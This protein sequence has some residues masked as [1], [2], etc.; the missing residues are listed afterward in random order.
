MLKQ[1]EKQPA[2]LKSKS[3][4]L[5]IDSTGADEFCSS[6][7]YEPTNIEESVLGN[8]Y[9][10]GEV[11]TF[12]KKCAYLVN[13]LASVIKKE[14]YRNHKRSPLESFEAGLSKANAY[15]ANI[16][17]QENID[18]I[19][20]IDIVCALLGKNQI[21]IS[22]VGDAR[23]LLSRDNYISPITEDSPQ[24]EPP[25][26]SKT[27]SNITSGP[28]IP[29]DKIVLST[30]GLFNML[31]LEEI[32]HSI[33]GISCKQAIQNIGELSEMDEDAETSSIILLDIDDPTASPQ[34]S[35]IQAGQLNKNQSIESLITSPK[36]SLKE[37][38]GDNSNYEQ[39]KISENELTNVSENDYKN[40]LGLKEKLQ[41]QIQ[42][43]FKK[44]LPL[45]NKTLLLLFKFSQ[46]FINLSLNVIKTIFSQRKK[47][48]N[49]FSK[50][51]VENSENNKKSVIIKIKKNIPLSNK[52]I[53]A[54]KS[55]FIFFTSKLAIKLTAVALIITFGTIGAFLLRNK[56][57]GNMEEISASLNIEKY[58]KL[59][60][61][62]Q[63]KKQD[64][65]TA[66]IYKDE[67][68]AKTLLAE[69]SEIIEESIQLGINPKE[70]TSLKNDIQIQLD[71]I[72]KI[73]NLQSPFSISDLKEISQD[74][75][76]KAH[77]IFGS[78]K[79]LMLLDY[80]N[81]QVAT[82]NLAKYNLTNQRSI[83]LLPNENIINSAI[84]KNGLICAI[85]NFSTIL[86]IPLEDIGV[87]HQNIVSS[88]DLSA[89][90]DIGVYSENIYLLLDSQN[91]ILKISSGRANS[92]LKETGID[93]S[94]AVSMAIDGNIFI[95]TSDKNVL[96]LSSGKLKNTFTFDGIDL[97][98]PN[99]IYTSA[100]LDKLFILD[101]PAKKIVITDKKGSVVEQYKSEKFDDLKSI[102]VDPKT[103][104]IY[105]LNG[106]CIYRIDT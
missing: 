103:G 54:R 7:T 53:T 40:T 56:Q 71:Q 25:F 92:W 89:I 13:S 41:T 21:H 101:P 60:E 31:S 77:A 94:Q 82:I 8:L 99:L 78:E 3:S 87:G 63:Q 46:K 14:L 45:A 80:K 79:N 26:P 96:Q 27:F 44:I 20:H 72:N 106:D 35:L 34:Q 68:K 29:G 43:I 10:A 42:N 16:A 58:Q 61:S 64:A 39:L 22:Q 97:Q 76:F 100:D 30:S 85:T 1:K 88:F 91:Q 67:K 15:L 86:K 5:F 47:V 65:E 70:T 74:N 33:S 23:V 105:I 19:G 11:K 83:T 17:S 6:F 81:I 93:L 90:K 24:E 32:K 50:K 55:F 69:A 52:E 48:F 98:S 4:E 37:I 9:I 57:T 62:A 102:Y 75:P 51:A 38:V 84:L 36:L 66:L 18:W 49:M 59:I 73:I 95:L 28:L 2:I 104:S 12:S